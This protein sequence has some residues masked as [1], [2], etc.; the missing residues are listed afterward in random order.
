M[1]SWWTSC[2][3]LPHHFILPVWLDY[4]IFIFCYWFYSLIGVNS[5]VYINSLICISAMYSQYFEIKTLALKDKLNKAYTNTTQNICVMLLI[6]DVLSDK[7]YFLLCKFYLLHFIVKENV[8]IDWCLSSS[9]V[10][11]W[12]I[13]VIYLAMNHSSRRTSPNRPV[14]TVWMAPTP[15]RRTHKG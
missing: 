6:S 2:F 15:T 9:V 13:R 5:F 12:V 11:Y 10:V 14:W 7:C 1:A 3:Y 8:G 4:F